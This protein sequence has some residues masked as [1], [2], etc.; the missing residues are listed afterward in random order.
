M[1]LPQVEGRLVRTGLTLSDISNFF[2]LHPT[3]SSYEVTVASIVTVRKRNT[4][5]GQVDLSPAVLQ[6]ILISELLCFTGRP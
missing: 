6:F 2:V 3:A 1:L 4:K 5:E